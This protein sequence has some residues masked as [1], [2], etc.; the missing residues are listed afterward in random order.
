M[1]LKPKKL[2]KYSLMAFIIGASLVIA[3]QEKAWAGYGAISYSPTAETNG[4]SNNKVSKQRA[5]EEARKYCGQSNCKTRWVKNGCVVLAVDPDDKQKY[6]FGSGISLSIAEND[7]K[8]KY[9]EY[10][11]IRYLCTSN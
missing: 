4:I 5:V 7:A 1:L 8:D 11:I 2:I 10:K 6:Y 3:H 9:P